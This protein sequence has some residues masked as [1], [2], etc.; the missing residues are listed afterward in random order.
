MR[1]SYVFELNSRKMKV[2]ACSESSLCGQQVGD[3]VYCIMRMQCDRVMG[4]TC[5]K[6]LWQTWSGKVGGETGHPPRRRRSFHLKIMTT[7]RYLSIHLST[8]PLPASCRQNKW[9]VDYSYASFMLYLHERPFRPFSLDTIT[10]RRFLFH[11]LKPDRIYVW[12]NL[13]KM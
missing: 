1:H 2:N 9:F 6:T 4:K 7:T 12:N 13:L 8:A 3:V 11:Y 5:G 10:Y